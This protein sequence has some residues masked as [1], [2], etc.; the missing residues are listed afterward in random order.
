VSANGCL[1][2]HALGRQTDNS[3][4][5]IASAGTCTGTDAALIDRLQAAYAGTTVVTGRTEAEIAAYSPG[6]RLLPPE[7]LPYVPGD[8][9]TGGTGRQQAPASSASTQ[10]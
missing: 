1:F 3:A 6:L 5:L 4:Q 10:A 7:R 2:E 9:I 8:P